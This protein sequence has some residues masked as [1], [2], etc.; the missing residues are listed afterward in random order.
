MLKSPHIKIDDL[1][2]L[3][4]SSKYTGR[5]THTVAYKHKK[6]MLVLITPQIINYDHRRRNAVV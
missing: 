2:L 5:I 6:P 4:Y 3:Y 1:S